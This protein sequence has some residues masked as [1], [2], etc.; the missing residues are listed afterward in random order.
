MSCLGL[1]GTLQNWG[2]SF[3]FVLEGPFGM[4]DGGSGLCGWGSGSITLSLFT[5]VLLID[6]P[7]EQSKVHGR[8]QREKRGFELSADP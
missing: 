2:T 5:N 8:R 4:D 1:T 6:W 7:F 3:I